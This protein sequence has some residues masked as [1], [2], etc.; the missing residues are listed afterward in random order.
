MVLA[1]MTTN[2][3]LSSIVKGLDVKP[4]DSIIAIAGSGDQA[5]ALLEYAKKVLAVD[6]EPFQV[7]YMNQMIEF[8]R[9]GDYE[10]FLKSHTDWIWYEREIIEEESFPTNYLNPERIERVRKKLDSLKVREG[11]IFDVIGQEE[12]FNKVYLSNMGGS[13]FSPYFCRLIK[14]V[15]DKLPSGGLIYISSGKEKGKSMDIC[16]E[17]VVDEHLSYLAR[18]KWLP[19]V[20]RKI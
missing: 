11:D 2:E 3:N 16:P 10:S 19:A 14:G 5:F 9:N 15:S 4:D 7:K 18:E 1:F 8:I 13:K 17:L 20:F 12:G 6:R